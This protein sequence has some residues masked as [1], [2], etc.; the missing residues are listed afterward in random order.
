MKEMSEREEVSLERETRKAQMAADRALREVADAADDDEDDDKPR[1]R[2]RNER[3]K[4]DVVLD[5]AFGI[6]SD[7]IR[8][9]GGAEVPRPRTNSGWYN[10][11]MGGF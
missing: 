9:N 8:L 1:R 11:I 2:K 3:S 6:M 7:L 5:A 4:D 10:A